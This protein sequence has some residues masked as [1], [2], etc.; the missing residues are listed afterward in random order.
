MPNMYFDF[1]A[2]TPLDLDVKEA[3]LPYLEDFYA[4]PSALYS[5]GQLA[6]NALED[7][8][9]SVAQVIGASSREII[10]TGS[11]TE[12]NNLAIFGIANAGGRTKGHIITTVIEH[13]SVLEPARALERRGF[14]VSYLSV[15][16]D[17][18]ISIDELRG[19][20]RNDTILVAIVYANNEIGTVQNIVEIGREIKNFG[21]A[22][23]HIDACQAANYLSVDVKELGVDSMSL[24]SSKIYGP[25]GV[26]MLYVRD[27]VELEPQIIG[28]GQERGRRSGTENLSGIVGFSKALTVAQELRVEESARLTLLK[29]QLIDGV[30]STIPDVHLNGSRHLRLPNNINFSFKGIE[31]EALL[32]AL[33]DLGVAVASGSA[34]GSQEVGSSHVIKAIKVSEEFASSATRITLGRQTTTEDIEY[35]LE[36]LPKVVETL[37]KES[38]FG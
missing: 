12:A 22:I 6:K 21:G 34:C 29:N 11:G 9:N 18:Q 3:M 2:A 23:F 16:S 35:L 36:I 32:S 19:A 27:G 1:A 25:K 20:L 37:R 38:V 33:D 14:E 13:K 10:F 30:I 17:G 7:A 28:G 24:N 15:D 8:R 26:G 31:G 4:N 5:V